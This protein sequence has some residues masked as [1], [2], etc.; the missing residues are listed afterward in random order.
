MSEVVTGVVK[1][2]FGFLANKI[3]SGI[4]ERLKDGDV[5]DEECRRLIVR[6]LDDIKSKLDGLARSSLLSSLCFLQE[7]MNGLYQSLIQLDSNENTAESTGQANLLEAASSR[8]TGSDSPINEAIA[9]ISTI[10]SLKVRSNDHF[11][12]AIESFKLAREKAAEAF[13][14]EALSIEDRIQAS[15]IRMMAR[16][17]EKL[18]H[19]DASASDC[20]QYLQQLHDIGAIQEIF[21]VLIEGGIKSRFNKTKRLNNASSVQVMNQVL[22]EFVKRLTKPSLVTRISAWPTILLGEK[23]YHPVLGEE[24]IIEKLKGTGMQVMSLG[25]DF[26]FH[27]ENIY[28]GFRSVVNSKGDIVALTRDKRTFKFFKPSGE[29]RILCEAPNEEHESEYFG[30]TA[31]DI[32]AE[33]NLYVI[34]RFRGSDDQSRSMKLS[35]FDEN[36]NKKLEC[37]L[38]FHQGSLA[39]G[40]MAI[41]KD[42]KIAIL[43]CEGKILYIGNICMELNSFEIDKSFSLEELYVRGYLSHA[44]ITIRFSN[45]NGTKIIAANRYTVYIY[46]EDGQIQRKI[47]IPEE[48]GCI[49]SV[50]INH[51]TQRILVQTCQQ[52]GRSLL[53]FSDTGELID[54]LCLGSSEWIRYAA[55]T[56][57]PKGP[58]VLVGLRKAAL[59]QL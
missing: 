10:T 43:N 27:D 52:P 37:P 58:V 50:A 51:V 38:P 32:D 19:P 57:H 18:E 28:S 4:V 20:L 36:G 15:Q 59:L 23:S 9:L 11:K 45:F 21:S 7:G 34:T 2:T 17:L 54:S 46:T 30:V 25:S 49:E 8:D 35:I 26:R 40:C 56:S 41:N 16:I 53:S 3:R 42:G 39:G 48:H 13:C 47:K 14:N 55:L 24:R 6:E 22:F 29:S 5:T 1:L 33:D 12:S 31:M 44:S